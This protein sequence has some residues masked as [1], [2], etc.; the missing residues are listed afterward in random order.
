MYHINNTIHKW[1]RD[2]GEE[3]QEVFEKIKLNIMNHISHKYRF[4]ETNRNLLTIDTMDEYYESAPH[5]N[6][7][8][9][10]VFITPHLDGFFGLIPFMRTWRCIYGLNGPHQTVTQ[11]PFS[12]ENPILLDKDTFYCFDYNRELHWVE[13]IDKE[14]IPHKLTRKIL[15][16]HF[17]DYPSWLSI[18]SQPYSW[19]HTQYNDIARQQF[20]FSQDPYNNPWT[21]VVS[22]TINT[23]T[24][25]GGSLERYFGFIHLMIISI[26]VK[27]NTLLSF[28]YM[29]QNSLA[30]VIFCCKET[31]VTTSLYLRDTGTYMT[32]L[33]GALT[34]CS[35]K[36]VYCT[37]IITNTY[38]ML[39]LIL[40]IYPTH[41]SLT[42]DVYFKE[43]NVFQTCH[44]NTMNQI[45]HIG[46][47]SMGILGMI[48]WIHFHLQLSYINIACILYLYCHYLIHDYEVQTWC[49]FLF[50]YFFYV[51]R[52]H[53]SY[54]QRPTLWIVGAM[55]LQELSHHIFHEETYLSTYLQ[56]EDGVYTFIKH[57]LWILPFE[58]R[59]IIQR[60]S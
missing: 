23:I 38:N 14:Y 39:F 57:G 5:I 3:T 54:F 44:Q 20:L 60:I 2:F 7:G 22:T 21:Y 51:L 43:L 25:L 37:P 26:L 56:K 52:K 18:F 12:E 34:V 42:E 9:D 6:I 11:I 16:L 53:A 35:L 15:K 29:I 1:T 55:C 58:L 24:F 17:F 30:I 47:T 28:T 46:T 27:K 31:N 41:H 49:L 48:Q 13:E 36:K 8:S 45:I 4:K 32:A 10:R 40:L 19:I 50:L 59:T 33:I